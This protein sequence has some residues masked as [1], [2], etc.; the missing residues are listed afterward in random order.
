[1]RTERVCVWFYESRCMRVH[2][3]ILYFLLDIFFVVV[4]LITQRVASLF[5]HALK[6]NVLLLSM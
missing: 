3:N 4:L 1:M 2:L 6:L 5:V